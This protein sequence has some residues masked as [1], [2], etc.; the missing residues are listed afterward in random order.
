MNKRVYICID[1]KSFYASVECVERGLNPLTTNL[2]VADS[3]R[4]QKTICL[5]VSPSLK[6][7][8]VSSRPR[9][10][11]VIQKVK[12]I[13]TARKKTINN[14]EFI[15]ESYD[16]NEL[17]DNSYLSLSYLV[18]TPQMSHYIDISAKIYGIYLKYIGQDDIHVY[19]IDEVFMD[20]S[21]YLKTYKMT[22]HDLAKT[23]IKDVLNETGITATAGIGTNMF[24]AKVAMD[25]VAKKMPADQ[26]GVRIA[27][28]DEKTYRKELWS[29]RPLKDFWRV[30][31][32]YASRLEKLGLYTM[33][34]IAKCSVGPITSY[35]NE[36]LLYQ[37][38]GVNAELLIDH[39][40]GIELTTMADIKKYRPK[41]TSVSS[42]QV[43]ACAYDYEKGKLI[44]KE[45]V[46]LLSLDLV[47]K[48]LLTKQ[49]SLSIG[50]DADSSSN[51]QYI[52]PMEI[53]HYGRKTPKGSH[54]S[55]NLDDYT[56][57]TTELMKAI[58]ILYK[59]IVN[60]GLLIKRVSISM[61]NL[62]SISDYHP[63]VKYQQCSLFDNSFNID[64]HAN[65]RK[66]QREKERKI[67][68]TIIAIKGKYGK[69]AIV[70]GM[71]LEDGGT[72]IERNKQIGGHKS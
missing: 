59:K 41:S 56:S 69:N 19:S 1:L 71:D 31:L 15:D 21:K 32:G 11:E 30:G 51:N 26:D 72:T 28:L 29:H 25:I 57:S 66:Q 55:I 4:S 67:Q 22:A 65:E 38:F 34:D 60:Q 18:A 45:M 37:E 49:L 6:S 53:D 5:A 43:L 40:W 2:V 35:Y 48:G 47:D 61:N 16:L 70:R 13:N 10:F 64:E 44:V 50:Y 24:L 12:D 54:G 52:G 9:L 68:K 63:Q 42:G 17:K 62:I 27:E 14:Q 33:G 3:S 39:A 23:M 58:T 36:D 7:F 46:E 20:V 8:G